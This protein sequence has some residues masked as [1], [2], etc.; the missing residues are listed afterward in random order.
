[1]AAQV[2]GLGRRALAVQADLAEA[3]AAGAVAVVVA[4]LVS[5]DA[6]FITGHVIYAA[7]GQRGPIRIDG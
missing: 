6:S 5:E 3:G 7:G 1:V 4:F 2:R